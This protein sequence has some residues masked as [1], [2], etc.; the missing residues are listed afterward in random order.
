MNRNIPLIIYGLASFGI[1]FFLLPEIA[2]G[3]DTTEIRKKNQYAWELRKTDPEKAMQFAYDALAKSQTINWRPGIE[4]SYAR[5]GVIWRRAGKFTRAL[6]LFQ[7]SL[8][9]REESGDSCYCAQGIQ[10][11][12]V[13]L[14]LKGDFKRSLSF[15]RRALNIRRNFDCGP[16]AIGKSFDSIGN[17]WGVQREYEKALTHHRKALVYYKKADSLGLV[18]NAYRN[19]G[20]DHYLDENLDSARY[21]AEM[22]ISL[23]AGR[24]DLE[25]LTDSYSFL[26]IVLIEQQKFNYAKKALDSAYVIAKDAG[27]IHEQALALYNLGDLERKRGNL[28]KG[29]E[30]FEKAIADWDT[31]EYSQEKA[32]SL[33]SLSELLYKTNRPG[34]AYQTLKMY[35]ELS[36]S[37]KGL[38]DDK[39]KA[40]METI[41]NLQEAEYEKEQATLKAE[42]ANADRKAANRR[43]LYAITIAVAILLLAA[44]LYRLQ[45]L[46]LRNARLEVAQRQQEHREKISVL[47]RESESKAL[48]AM[49]EGQE[50]ERGRIAIDLH[51]N[52]GSLLSTVKLYFNALE[53]QFEELPSQSKTPFNKAVD[54]MDQ[55]VSE[56]RRIAHNMV[57]GTL[58]NAGLIPALEEMADM[59]NGTQ[60]ANVRVIVPTGMERCPTTVEVSLFRIVQELVSNAVRHGKAKQIT[61]QI[62]CDLE[63][64]RL[65]VED[66]GEGFEPRTLQKKGIGLANIKTR[67][68]SLQG[69][70]HLDSQPGQG[71][72][73]MITIPAASMANQL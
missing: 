69:E 45:R 26:G 65:S 23:L 17:Y 22:A 52:L 12:A 19:L 51:D 29:I 18:I 47:M 14:R 42:L 20:N 43:L 70:F 64:V 55:A 67:V 33:E 10:N 4:E 30:Y 5:L 72:L 1:L 28:A 25:L 41:Y 58:A 40:E 62:N 44:L 66:N 36:D 63:E 13:T 37:I 73:V 50:K 6:E 48:Q 15:F 56:V 3:S 53:R 57:T 7:K 46:R 34:K 32:I 2:R 16:L 8:A 31:I 27:F 39:M 60:Q 71:T 35:V 61:V 59:I 38:N 21:F 24:K 9:I 11:I 49:F 68:R 54:L